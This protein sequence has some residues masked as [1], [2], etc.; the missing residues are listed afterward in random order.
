MIEGGK[1][2]VQAEGEVVSKAELKA[3]RKRGSIN[4]NG[5]LA[6]T[7]ACADTTHS[8]LVI[9]VGDVHGDWDALNR[10]LE[11]YKPDTALVAGDMGFFPLLGM[12]PRSEVRTTLSS[13]KKVEVRFCDGNHE[14]HNS[15]AKVAGDYRHSPCEIAE[16]LIYQPR[17]SSAT[18]PDGRT[19][20][21]VGGAKSVD[22][23][24]RVYGVTWFPQEVLH[25]EDLPEELVSADVV[26][27]H[28]A[29]RSLGLQ[30]KLGL[31]TIPS[32]WD[33]SPDP[34]E[35]VLDEILAFTA[36]HIWVCGHWHAP[37]STR[38]NNTML[39]VLDCLRGQS[40]E[41]SVVFV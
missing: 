17:G 19:A 22:R 39:H 7:P 36:P 24:A 31:K 40:C 3:L 11:H 18:L 8:G 38:I 4:W 23:A 5:S 20:L 32:W 16:N 41:N 14:D 9:A 1:T 30:T 2:A 10:V 37:Y 29:P 15:L 33:V 28:T 35:L 34:S 26:V 6:T 27:S 13:G 21:F 25:K 12:D